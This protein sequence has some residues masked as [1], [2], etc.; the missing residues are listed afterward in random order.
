M[1]LRGY[2]FSRNFSDGSFVD[3]STQNAVIRQACEKNLYN[4]K[5]S[6]TEYGMKNCFLML[7]KL[8]EDLNS[9][10][11]NGIAFY[12]IYQLP[13]GTIK[14]K[15]FDVALKKEKKILFSKQD[16]IIE[17]KE[18]IVKLDELISLIDIQ[19]S[20]LKKINNFAKKSY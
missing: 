12:S 8:I 4:F 7:E 20:C 17:K 19:K 1:N 2:I 9:K 18:D 11:I 13:S 5:L 16:I 15:L 14:K 3:Q 10:H 6:A